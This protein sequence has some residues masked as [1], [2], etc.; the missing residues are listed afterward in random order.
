M[1]L[2]VRPMQAADLAAVERIHKAHV[3]PGN[4]PGR[5]RQSMRARIEEALAAP[6]DQPAVALVG[7]DEKDR[8]RGYLVGEVRSWEFGSAPAGWIFAVGV[9]PRVERQG[10]GRALL[11]EAVAR[12]RAL[13]VRTVRTMVQ[14]EDVPVLRFFR[15]GHFTAGP[16]VELELNLE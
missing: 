14:K 8:V 5:R 7:V 3:A 1:P 15:S 11:D 2:S 13:G 4:A 16:Y 10:L 9:D 12:F 6:P